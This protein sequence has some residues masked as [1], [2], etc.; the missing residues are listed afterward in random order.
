MITKLLFA[1]ISLSLSLNAAPE[2]FIKLLTLDDAN[3]SLP[4][5]FGIIEDNTLWLNP[6][7]QCSIWLESF[8]KLIKEQH[9]RNQPLML[10]V[11]ESEDA[12]G[13]CTYHIYEAH[14]LNTIFFNNYLTRQ[15]HD[16]PVELIQNHNDPETRNICHRVKYYML[17]SGAQSFL[18]VGHFNKLDCLKE[19]CY[20]SFPFDL[21]DDGNTL[22]NVGFAYGTGKDV[23]QNYTRARMLYEQGA[24]KGNPQGIHNLGV[25]YYDGLGVKQDYAKAQKLFQE[26]ANLGSSDSMIMLGHMYI[27]GAVASRDLIE[28]VKLFKQAAVSNS[29]AINDLYQLGMLYKKGK[30]VALDWD[31]AKEILTIAA[32]LGHKKAQH[33]L[34]L[35][36]KNKKIKYK[37]LFSISLQHKNVHR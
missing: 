21:E 8:K 31:K 17:F 30:K 32:E 13:E 22:V 33:E 7:A 28:A 29:D 6:K 36:E 19:L 26:A 14:A 15:V 4:E 3:I 16:Q 25:L 35:M 5:K 2:N 12:T 24:S 20:E 9:S 37:K 10:A 18:Y 11:T 1:I 27:D 23:A 34:D